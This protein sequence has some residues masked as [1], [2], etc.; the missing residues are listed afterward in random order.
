MKLNASGNSG[1]HSV[2]FRF[3][4]P[5]ASKTEGLIVQDASRSLCYPLLCGHC[6][7]SCQAERQAPGLHVETL[8]FANT[9]NEE[10]KFLRHHDF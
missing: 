1:G 7:P 8:L 4:K 6:L 5:C 9:L 3:Q 2:Y 10:S